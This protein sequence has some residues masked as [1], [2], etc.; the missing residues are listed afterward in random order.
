[1]SSFR[2]MAIA[3]GQELRARGISSIGRREC[4]TIIGNV[5]G[6]TSAVLSEALS[7][8]PRLRMVLGKRQRAPSRP[9]GDKE[10]SPPA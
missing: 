10:K 4:E 3:L 7:A 1:M 2:L 9:R 5:V 8:P 6:R